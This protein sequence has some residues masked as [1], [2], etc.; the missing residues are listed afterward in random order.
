MSVIASRSLALQ[1]STSSAP[2]ICSAKYPMKKIPLAV[3]K[4]E[5]VRPR[6]PFIP[7][8][9]VGDIRAVEIVRDV[10]EKKKRQESRRNASART[11]PSVYLRG[12]HE[13][14]QHNVARDAHNLNPA[15]PHVV[16][17][18]GHGAT[19]DATGAG[20]VNGNA[21]QFTWKDSQGNTGT[22]TI[23]R[24][25]RRYRRLAENRACRRPTLS[26]VL[27][28]K[29]EAEAHR[30]EVVLDWERGLRE[31]AHS[32]IFA[33]MRLIARTPAGCRGCG[34]SGALPTTPSAGIARRFPA[35]GR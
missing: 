13:C 4:T 8:R 31:P 3:P 7:E 28:G 19:P 35:S 14:A 17:A 34:Q 11:C 15:R 6:S 5:S 29:H 18:D 22:G 25:W 32:D 10:K 24:R 12:S 23:N 26:R 33:G 16:F 30:E 9:R 20:K 2:G 1:R 21:A 27:S